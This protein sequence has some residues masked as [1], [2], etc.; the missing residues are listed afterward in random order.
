MAV[1]LFLDGLHKE[2]GELLRHLGDFVFG[3]GFL[4]EV[5]MVSGGL[6]E[7]NDTW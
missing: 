2:A 7:G 6:A 5:L 4:I 3:E 1:G